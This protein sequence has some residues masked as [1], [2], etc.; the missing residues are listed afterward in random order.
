MLR[1]HPIGR[2]IPQMAYVPTR[3]WNPFDGSSGQPTLRGPSSSLSQPHQAPRDHTPPQYTNNKNPLWG[4]KAHDDHHKYLEM[5]SR[6]F[7]NKVSTQPREGQNQRL[8]PSHSEPVDGAQT[9][10]CFAAPLSDKHPRS[11]PNQNP[12]TQHY[13]NPLSQQRTSYQKHTASEKKAHRNGD[14]TR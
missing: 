5:T 10:M 8:P 3:Q 7:S 12:D 14:G 13:T 9:H 4:D 1:G 2:Y 11:V 6:E